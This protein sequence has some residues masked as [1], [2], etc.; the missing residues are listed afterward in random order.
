MKGARKKR[1][2]RGRARRLASHVWALSASMTTLI[3]AG[4]ALGDTPATLVGPDLLPRRVSVQGLGDGAVSYFDANKKYA[5]QPMAGVVQMRDVGDAEAPAPATAAAAWVVELIDGQR[6]TGDSAPAAEGQSLTWSHPLLGKVALKLDDLQSI[7]A[8]GADLSPLDRPEP[9][10]RLLLANGDIVR[11]FVSGFKSGALE[12]KTQG[13]ATVALPLE[14]VKAV[15]FA[16]PSRAGRD[17]SHMVWLDDS[18]RVSATELTIGEDQLK[19]ESPLASAPA[20]AP[21]SEEKKPAAKRTVTMPLAKIS[22]IDF[23]SP[24]GRLVPLAGLAATTVGGG[25]VFG[26]AV[27]PRV[28]GDAV[29]L[30]APVTVKYELPAGAQRFAAEASLDTSNAAG[31]DPVAWAD[32]DVVASVDGKEMGRWNISGKNP[33]AAIN[34]EAKGAALTIELVP[35]INGPVL[36]RLKLSNAVVLVK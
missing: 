18:S 22:R 6:L 33:I 29:A 30:H 20:A 2:T 21:G 1:G 11:G 25:E 4:V 17:G 24:S 23:A 31:A 15:R 32:F 28:K 16:N 19:F 7:A 5:T 8:A 36:D 12:V 13:G 10:D 27:A 26:M 9:G 35:G 14:R 3:G 34:F